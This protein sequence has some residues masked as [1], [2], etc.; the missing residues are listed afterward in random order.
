MKLSNR[1]FVMW[2]YDRKK[3]NTTSMPLIFNKRVR[4]RPIPTNSTRLDD[5][6]WKIRKKRIMNYFINVSYN[7]IV[8][9]FNS[10]VPA[11]IG[12]HII[13]CARINGTWWFWLLQTTNNGLQYN[14]IRFAAVFWWFHEAARKTIL[15][16]RNGFKC[17]GGS[18][19]RKQPHFYNDVTKQ[20]QIKSN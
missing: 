16:R 9:A 8:R 15:V 18:N 10:C 2:F 12:Y 4:F 1:V 6:D 19:L 14:N 11:T 5:D 3:I 13:S 20:V 7:I 17:Y